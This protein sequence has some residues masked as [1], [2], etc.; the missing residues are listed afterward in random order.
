MTYTLYSNKGSGG[1]A[2]EAALAKAGAPYTIVRVDYDK[3]EQKSAAFAKINPMQQIPA[4]TLPDG[5]LM[6]ESAAM[7][8]HLAQ[9][10]PGKR[11]APAMGTPGH[12]KFLRWML[13][14]A[15]NLY[16]ADLRYFYP[17]RYTADAA[18]ADA[19]KASGAAHMA[20]SFA[21]IEQELDP[22]LFGNDL[23]IADVYLAMLAQWSPVPL[24]TPKFV[25]LGKSVMADPAYGPVFHRHFTKD[26]A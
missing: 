14:M 2:V 13:F 23:S 10:F 15:V 12:A 19:V 16:E 24:N 1:F 20:K 17:G 3:D 8:I 22:F 7:A 25:S 21:V 4:M 11:L 5:T 6:T 26:T 18:G 9:A